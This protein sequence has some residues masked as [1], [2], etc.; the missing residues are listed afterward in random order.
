MIGKTI[1]HFRIAEKL[2]EGGMGEVYRATD[3][4]LNRDVALKILPDGFTK[5]SQRMARFHREAKVLASLNHS[6][7]GAI[8]GLEESESSQVLVLEIV[9][10][11]TLAER[12]AK[13]PIPFDEAVEIAIQIANAL[14]AA[15]EKGIIH[16]DLKPAN[17][18][19]RPDG[20][21][22]VLDFGLAK[23]AA[24]PE[25]PRLSE[26]ETLTSPSTQIG[27]IMGTPAYMS[28]EQARGSL[29]DHRTDVWAFGVVFFEMLTGRAPF[30]GEGA[31]DIIA[32]VVTQ[33]P[34]WELLP[35]ATP[36]SARQILRRCLARNPRSRLHHIADARL[37][38]ENPDL[39][40]S[41]DPGR[42]SR[43]RIAVAVLAIALI[44][45]LA[46]VLTN[47]NPFAFETGPQVENPL[48]GAKFSKVTDFKGSEF[49]AAISPDGQFVTFVSDRDGPFEVL[50]GQVGAGDFR[51]LLTDGS[52]FDL[53][54][55]RAPLRSV[56]FNHDG[57]EIW[58]GG[59]PWQRVRLKP[60]MGGSTRY[61]L[62][63]NV[64]NVSWSPD[65]R[66]IVYHERLAGDPVYVADSNGT[67][68]RKI[69]SPPAGTHQHFPVFSLDGKWIY[70][71]RGRP[72]TLEMDL[73]RVRTDGQDL[74]QL[75][76]RKLDVRYP[77]PI[78]EKTV[79]YSA[80]DTD[81]AGPWLWSLD[82]ETRTSRRASIG[83]EQYSSVSSSAGG[84]RLVATVQDA[85]AGLWSVPILDRIA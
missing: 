62:G 51:K 26:S 71:S 8:Y 34:D 72:A 47:W 82:V 44:A 80:R 83:L 67:N 12:I 59:G 41:A 17:I 2:G 31:T 63:E 36:A 39:P 58:L 65:G 27:V 16:R 74:E 78:D 37:Q 21:V 9:E 46:A 68:S 38:L 56:G 69:L 32:A 7:I 60:L 15:H 6:N 10:G 85:R 55:A 35:K 13:R 1:A 64:V 77:T 81:G 5:D 43:Y 40:P 84:Q 50:V 4:K 3:T 57:S 30:H 53:E 45:S 75:T 73:W 19:I 20:T 61:F 79:L 66:Q 28:P 54:D 18:K 29:V 11:T 33:E 22:K 42:Q 48:A 24:P 25:E 70:I 23:A 76:W 14:E 52:G 49:D